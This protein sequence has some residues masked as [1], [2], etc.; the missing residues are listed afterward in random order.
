M[1]EM[2]VKGRGPNLVITRSFSEERIFK[3]EQEVGSIWVTQLGKLT[4]EKEEEGGLVEGLVGSGSQGKGTTH[5]KAPWQ[6]GESESITR[7]AG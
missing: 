5:A 6:E 2:K 1:S 7:R 4:Q 3:L